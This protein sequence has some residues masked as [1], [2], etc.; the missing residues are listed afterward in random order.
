[1]RI[2]FHPEADTEFAAQIEYY[3]AREAGLG[4]RYYREVMASLEWIANHPSVPR[5]RK[6][7]RRLNLKAFPFYIAYSVE[8]DLIWVLAVAHCKRRPR[9]WTKR[10]Q[11]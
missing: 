2:E 8:S 9:Y 3:E 4:V 10:S 11:G 6:T 1:M 7:F 5:L